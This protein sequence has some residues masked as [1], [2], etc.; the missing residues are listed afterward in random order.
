MPT[1]QE[2]KDSILAQKATY[3]SLDG[4]NS[5]SNTAIYNLWAYVVAAVHFVLY[6]FFDLFKLEVDEKIAA[7]K[8]YSLK[9]FRDQA[10]AFRNGHPLVEQGYNLVYLADGYTEQEIADALIIKR[11]AVEELEIEG[12]K[13]LFIKVATEDTNGDLQP[14]T[15]GQQTSLVDY[16]QRIKPAGTKLEISSENADDLRLEVD[17]YYDPLILGDT[18]TRIDGTNNQPV[19]N[20]IRSYIANLPFNGEFSIAELE[21]RLQALSGCSEREAYVRSAESRFGSQ[22]YQPI[23]S[24][25]IATSGYMV[26]A[27]VDLTINFIA[28][29]VAE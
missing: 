9:W 5:S 14:I 13:L 17:F 27:D 21:D 3:S 7:Q 1:I 22:L 16:F 26:I 18:G 6:Q 20:E 11:A 10:L 4:L 19:Q 25:K 24:A 23:T 2:I 29:S 28:K 12:R 8:I 15:T